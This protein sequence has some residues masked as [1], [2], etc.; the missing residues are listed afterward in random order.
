M[1]AELEELIE[2]LTPFLDWDSGSRIS[3]EMEEHCGLLPEFAR[4]QT[5][6]RA[7]FDKVHPPLPSPKP[8]SLAAMSPGLAR[9][10]ASNV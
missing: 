2:A 5:A 9:R 6:Y 7:G 10:E 4:L 8:G 3:G 1:G